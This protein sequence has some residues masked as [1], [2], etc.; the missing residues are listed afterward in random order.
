MGSHH[1][2][3]IGSPAAMVFWGSFLLNSTTVGFARF[4]LTMLAAGRTHRGAVTPSRAGPDVRG[5]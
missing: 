3:H 2:V 4:Q 5:D 1:L